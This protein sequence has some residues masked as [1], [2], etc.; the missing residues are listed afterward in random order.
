MNH[1]LK[2]TGQTVYLIGGTGKWIDIL[3]PF[4]FKS[5]AGYLGSIQKVRKEKIK[6]VKSGYGA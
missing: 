6:S 1:I 2:S 5:K 3:I 4:G